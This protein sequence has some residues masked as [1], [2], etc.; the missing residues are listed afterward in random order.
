MVSIKPRGRWVTSALVALCLCAG[1][2]SGAAYAGKIHLNIE[3]KAGKKVSKSSAVG[4]VKTEYPGSRILSVS[5]L[6]VDGKHCHEVKALTKD[7]Y[8]L[9]VRVGCQ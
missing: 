5:E 4:R 3:K 7:G 8:F 9:E 1:A 6:S 2:Y